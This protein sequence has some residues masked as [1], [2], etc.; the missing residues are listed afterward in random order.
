MLDGVLQ[1]RGLNNAV[2]ANDDDSALPSRAKLPPVDPKKP[3]IL[4]VDPEVSVTIPAGTTEI[5]VNLRDLG[6]DGGP[7]FPYRLTVEPV[8][9]GFRSSPYHHDQVNIPRGGTAGIGVEVERRDFAGPITPDHRRP[10]RRP[11]RPPRPRPRRANGGGLDRL[12]RTRRVVRPATRSGSSATADRPTGPIVV[13]ATRTTILARQADFATR[14]VDPSRP[15]R[16][17]RRRRRR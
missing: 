7:N 15:P 17:P 8:T 10:A 5:T 11:D 16:R 1:V 6:D 14:V 12:G 9:P 2:L 3:P 13:E 4:S